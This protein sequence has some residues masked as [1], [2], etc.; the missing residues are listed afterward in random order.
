MLGVRPV[1]VIV[2]NPLHWLVQAGE[3]GGWLGWLRSQGSRE[4]E[5]LGHQ[6]SV[7]SKVITNQ[8]PMGFIVGH[9]CSSF[10][11]CATLN[12]VPWFVKALQPV[13]YLLLCCHPW[14]LEQLKYSI[15]LWKQL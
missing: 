11:W 3:G 10:S 14:H 4:R 15:L 9:A 1:W 8:T 12:I 2:H 13:V 7:A 6:V 5:T